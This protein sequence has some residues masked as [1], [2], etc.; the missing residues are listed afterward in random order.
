M[1]PKPGKFWRHDLTTR[2]LAVRMVLAC[3]L[4]SL[5]ALPSCQKAVATRDP[6]V[7]ETWE[8]FY[9]QNAKIGYGHSTVRSI[10]RQG[11]SLVEVKSLNH[12]EISRFGQ[13]TEQDVKLS[14]L[15]TP[16]GELLEFATDMAT[17]PAPVAVS[18]RVEHGKMALEIKTKGRQ[19]KANIPWSSDIGGFRAGR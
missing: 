12:L 8:A 7:E 19:E 10:N 1:I 14:T 17:G 15:E 2:E 16:D 9:L 11:R 3:C 6:A 5:A 18:G 13:R 4:A